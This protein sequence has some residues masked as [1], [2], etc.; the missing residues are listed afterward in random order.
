[1]FRKALVPLDFSDWSDAALGLLASLKGVGTQEATLLHV[2]DSRPVAYLPEC[3]PVDDAPLREGALEALESRRQAAERAGVRAA[4]QVV[5]GA[6]VEAIVQAA[7]TGGAEYI[8]MGSRRRSFLQHV[9]LGTV[10]EN[11][12][13]HAT[14]PVLLDKWS[15]A[16][17]PAAPNVFE[18]VLFPTDFSPCAEKAFRYLA[19]LAAGGMRRAT[20][21]HVQDT[22][23]ARGRA[24]AIAHLE[25]MVDHDRLAATEATLAGLGVETRTVVCEGLPYREAL[26]AAEEE[27][28]TAIVLGSHGKSSVAEIL[29]G[30]VSAEIIRQ[31]RVPVLVVRRD[32]N[33][34][35]PA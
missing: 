16:A 7:A 20:I 11:V 17:H 8:L 33:E 27:G 13:R 10:S 14:V 22:R 6:P 1:M 31:A 24:D 19:E 5:R 18:H 32:L 29:L 15:G 26:R 25:Q 28:V 2:M 3:F 35:E 30:S 23:G 21:L 4:V 34:E 12:I 9:V